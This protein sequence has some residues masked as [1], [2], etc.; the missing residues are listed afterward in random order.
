M[1][2]E[3]FNSISGYSIGIPPIE[4]IDS[5]GNLKTNVLTTGNVAASNVYANQYFYANGQPIL[6]V[7]VAGSNT[8]VQFNDNMQLGASASFTFDGVS[9]LLTITN[10]SVTGVSNLGAVGN[11]VITGG[12]T[13]YVLTTDGTGNLSWSA[14]GSNSSPG[15]TNTQVQ[16]NDNGVLNGTSGLTFNKT[17]NTLSTVNVDA[18]VFT[19]N[20]Y[21]TA[22]VAIVAGTVTVSSQP[23]IT[24]VGT[25]TSVSV[26]GTATVGNLV[27]LGTF[28][29]NGISSPNIT[30]N[31]L[32]VNSYFRTNSGSTTEFFGNVNLAFA[33]NVD[34]GSADHLTISGGNAG[35]VLTTNGTG[36]ITWSPAPG[37]PG[38]SNTQVQYNDNGV[39]G[40][41]PNFTYN[42]IT[43][44]LTIAGH[45]VANT[46][47]MGSGVYRF[48]TT[49]VLL[50]STSSADP[51]QV[52]YEVPS[53][54][55]SSLD[56]VIISTDISEGT[57]TSTKISATVLGS[58]VAYTEFAGIHING[59]V[60]SFEVD[61]M[62]GNVLSPAVIRLLCS[63]DS[64]NYTTH[65]ILI[66]KYAAL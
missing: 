30:S 64:A 59:G 7:A 47:Q 40:G 29:A 42:D 66:T 41:S 6:M 28:S 57:R 8:Q 19:G 13:G 17:T 2:S 48:F 5:N 46:F 22:N 52:I 43:N 15:G 24:S 56:F 62:S 1:A 58:E 31:S 49:E 16:F 45:L 32:I 26:S 65:N 11:I 20:L 33:P 14:K 23:N 60:G 12:N 38:G 35:Y 61:Y 18:N 54:Q 27:T 37:G 25:L 10:L 63:P 55:V 9:N 53:A 39:L 44:T 51:A 50:S 3:L 21:G 4:V 36:N 34:L